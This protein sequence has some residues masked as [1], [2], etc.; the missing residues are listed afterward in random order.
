MKTTVFAGRIFLPLLIALVIFILQ[1]CEKK[2]ETQ[3]AVEEI[4]ASKKPPRPP[5]YFNNCGNPVIKG[6]FV[7]GTPA[8]VTITLNYVN[9]SGGSYSSFTSATVNGITMTAPPGTLNNGTGS[10]TLTARGTPIR[11]GYFIIPVSIAGSTACNLPITVTNAGVTESTGD[12]GTVAG[13]TGTVSFTYQNQPVIYKTVRAADGKIWTQHNLGSTRVAFSSIDEGSYGHVFQWG[14]WDDGHQVPTSSV[15]TGTTSIQNPSQ[16]AP[17]NPAFI[18]NQVP[19]SAWWGTG[20]LTTDTWSGS[21]PTSVNGKDPCA[22]LGAGWRMPT[23]ADWQNII[24]LESISDMHTAFRSNLKLAAGYYRPSQTGI[25]AQNGD[26]GH[27]WTSTANGGSA[28]AVFI[29]NAYGLFI[30]PAERGFGLP[31][32]CVKD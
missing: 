11:A 8:N 6:T 12:P 17:G 23:A 32:R 25:V 3:T 16:I 15:I 7:V 30:S 4:A 22:A 9:G 21:I 14:R 19:S 5:L 26:V 13:S 1:A 2:V 31:C 20:G 24:N 18:K 27:F 29:D 10:I 28:M